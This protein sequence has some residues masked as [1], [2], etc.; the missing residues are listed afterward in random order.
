M[1][2]DD[3]L[4]ALAKLADFIEAQGGNKEQVYHPE[5]LPKASMTCEVKAGFDGFVDNIVCE[6]IGTTSL[7]LGG[8]RRNK[9]DQIDLAVGVVLKKKVGDAVTKDDTIAVIHAN[10]AAKMKEAKE[11]LYQAYSFSRNKPQDRTLIKTIIR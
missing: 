5:T 1:A 4:A 10:D 8:G 11:R 2:D 7:L 3:V 9:T 6:E